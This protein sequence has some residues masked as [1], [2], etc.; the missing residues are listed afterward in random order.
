MIE[1]I[2]KPL[3]KSKSKTDLASFANQW[4]KPG[5][6]I[7]RAL[8]YVVSAV[9]FRNG[10]FPFYGLKSFLLRLFG[11]EVGKGVLIK[12]YVIIKYPWLLKLGNHI[13]I[14]ERVWIDNLDLIVIGNNVCLSQGCY[15][16]TGNHNYKSSTF[17]LLISQIIL[18][19]GVWIGAN[20]IV[21]PGITC[22]SHSMLT[23]GSI[24]VNDMEAYSIYQGNPAIKMKNRE[25]N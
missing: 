16:V 4:Y 21:G 15:L 13:W 3:L 12:P 18:E 22:R 7:K 17:D 24:L 10:L 9:V 11:A 1:Q 23:L 25:I 8:W 2:K 20:S 14:G 5:S 6:S 19:D